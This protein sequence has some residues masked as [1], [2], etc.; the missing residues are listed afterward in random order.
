MTN[1]DHQEPDAVRREPPAPDGDLEEL[2]VATVE[3]LDAEEDAD[4]VRGRTSGG[5]RLR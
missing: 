5:C 1:R 4:D 2:E 3:D